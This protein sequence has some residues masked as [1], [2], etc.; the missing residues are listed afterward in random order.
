MVD[1]MDIPVACYWENCV[2]SEGKRGEIKSVASM[3]RADSVLVLDASILQVNLTG[4]KVEHGTE[5]VMCLAT[6]QKRR[7]RIGDLERENLPACPNNPAGNLKPR[8]H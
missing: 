8:W 5:A 6:E 3:C 1:V 7:G 2:A 4:G